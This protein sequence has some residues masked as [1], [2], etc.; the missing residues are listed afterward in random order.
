MSY[1]FYEAQRCGPLPADQRVKWRGNSAMSDGSDVGKDLLGGY[2]DGRWRQKG[3][4][5]MA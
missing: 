1:L 5:D 2:F 3:F 4:V